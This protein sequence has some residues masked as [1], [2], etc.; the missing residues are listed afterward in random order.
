MSKPETA[1][2]I[3]C[4]NEE[5]WIGET[6]RRLNKQTYQDFEIVVVDS[7][8]TDKTLNIV[9][10]FNTT[11]I[12]IPPEDFTYPYA[13]NVGIKASQATS[14]YVMLSAHSLPISNEWL[15]SGIEKFYVQNN[16]L[17]V[18][19]PLRSLPHTTLCDKLVHDTSY[20]LDYLLSRPEG[21]RLITHGGMG[22]LGFTNA[23]IR[24]DLW[25]KYPINESFAGGG[26]DGDWVNYWLAHGY[27]AVKDFTFGVRHSHNLGLLAWLKQIQHWRKVSR[28][29]QFEYLDYRVEPAHKRT[30]DPI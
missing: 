6:L 26:E 28:P 29:Q 10:E 24:K 23:I 14:Y 25:E 5:R 9:E 13:I 30:T 21:Y 3:R 16:V 1:V 17:G 7:G 22:V 12:T 11:L 19:G 27:V 20:F 4:R 15:K 2:I 8:S 18:Y